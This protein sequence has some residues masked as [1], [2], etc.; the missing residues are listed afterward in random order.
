MTD[1]EYTQCA[2]DTILAGL[3]TDIEKAYASWPTVTTRKYFDPESA[4]IAGKASL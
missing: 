3:T 2:L 4:L 1:I